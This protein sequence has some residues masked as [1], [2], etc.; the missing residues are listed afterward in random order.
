MSKKILAIILAV[1]ILGGGIFYLENVQKNSYNQVQVV[2]P[3]KN[4]S[5]ATLVI[6]NQQYQME[7]T[8]SSTV[9]D[10]MVNLKNKGDVNFTANNYTGM[11]ELIEEINGIKG[12][13]KTNTYWI[14]YINGKS[15]TEG[16]SSYIVKPNDVITWKYEKS[17][18]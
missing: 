8:S 2:A 4:I 7:V 5:T 14:Y 3:Q 11:G 1:L 13:T 16:I 12:D 10:L 15:A 9:Y 6:G 18:F 17:T